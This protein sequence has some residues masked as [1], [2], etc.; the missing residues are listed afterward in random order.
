MMGPGLLQLQVDIADI[1]KYVLNVFWG[2]RPEEEPLRPEAA[3]ILKERQTS[4]QDFQGAYCL[5]TSLPAAM[6]ILTFKMIQAP[7]QI[8]VVLENGDPVRQIHTDGRSLPKDPDPNWM[9]YSVG[10][11]QRDT[12]V[13]E[14]V[15]ITTR[16]WLDGFG[17]PRSE[18]MR[19]TERYRRRDFGHMDLEI[20]FEDPE[21]L[22]AAVRLQDHTDAAARHRRARI[23]LHGELEEPRALT[24]SSEPERLGVSLFSTTTRGGRE[25]VPARG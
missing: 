8:V 19:I 21:Y 15:G 7:N 14:T 23:R 13:V 22:H 25:R 17:H 5:P 3:A 1:T 20:S 12:L 10:S 9:G 2:L 16:A 6:S 24:L 11:W 4:G 18:G